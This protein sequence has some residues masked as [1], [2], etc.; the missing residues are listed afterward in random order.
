[1]RLFK[2]GDTSGNDIEIKP[3]QAL[4]FKVTVIDER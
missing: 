4:T 1:M 2:T 3:G